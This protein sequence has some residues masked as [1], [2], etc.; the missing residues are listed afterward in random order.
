MHR[1][2][3]TVVV[4]TFAV[5]GFVTGVAGAAPA[6]AGGAGPATSPPAAE[7]HALHAEVQ[8]LLSTERGLVGL[9]SNRIAATTGTRPDL[10]PTT[11]RPVTSTTDPD[12]VPAA[13]TVPPQPVGPGTHA[14]VPVG[15][16]GA[17]SDDTTPDDPPTGPAPVPTTAPPPSTTTSTTAPPP[18]PPSTTTT[19]APRHDG[20]GGSDD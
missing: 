11:G 16:T 8:G 1:T 15:A 10:D 20:G 13:S 7:E 18:P 9:L 12:A 2:F 19:T 17:P 3:M 5:G 14:T 6:P 4:T